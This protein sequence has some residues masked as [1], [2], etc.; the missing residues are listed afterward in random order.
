MD[1]LKLVVLLPGLLGCYQPTFE[2]CAIACTPDVACPG[3]LTCGEDRHCHGPGEE[4]TCT[5]DVSVTVADP[6][7]TRGIVEVN[8][9]PCAEGCTLEV[10]GGTAMDIKLSADST[11]VFAL[12]DGDCEQPRNRCELTL[13]RNTTIAATLSPGRNVRVGFTGDGD[14][15]VESV[16]AGILCTGPTD[17]DGCEEVFSIDEDI[18]LSAVPVPPT[19]F[20]TW[21]FGDCAGALDCEIKHESAN[22]SL[23]AR[24]DVRRLSV[25]VVGAA[26]DSV[27]MTTTD[28]VELPT[29]P[30]A[31]GTCELLF[32]PMLPAQDIVLTP[33]SGTQRRLR[34]WFGVTSCD[35]VQGS[36]AFQL[37]TAPTLDATMVAL[38]EPL[39]R[40]DVNVQ[41]GQVTVEGA[42]VNAENAFQCPVNGPAADATC[43]Y[44]VIPGSLVAIHRN[45][46]PPQPG[47]G[48]FTPR[49]KEWKPITMMSFPACQPLDLDCEITMVDDVIVAGIY[50]PPSLDIKN[51]P[52]DG[53][54]KVDISVDGAAES[55]CGPFP[56]GTEAACVLQFKTGSMI[57]LIAPPTGQWSTCPGAIAGQAC[58]FTITGSGAASLGF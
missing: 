50:N 1:V 57:E 51:L 20:D 36:C 13:S 38:F 42:G 49:F 48:A 43:T 27:T 58:R 4:Q 33:V 21:T 40:L 34:Q 52:A 11:N 22:A 12:F 5:F 6:A 18:V 47:E 9:T 37:G 17:V 44:F 23:Q 2:Q 26:T 41:E 16:P 30:C 56:V 25:T 28:G 14:G 7:G 10:L 15:R 39:F 19:R 8:G 54:T 53:V 45:A 24:F 32:D 55:A 35:S 29:S 46:D 31:A 3:D